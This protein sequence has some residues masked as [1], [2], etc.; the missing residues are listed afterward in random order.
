MGHRTR[1]GRSP[2]II[3]IPL[4]TL[5]A[6]TSQPLTVTHAP[7]SLRIVAADSCEPLVEELAAAYEATHPWVTVRVETLNSTLAEETLRAG[8]ADL[9]ALSWLEEDPQE[10]LWSV[11]FAT[12]AVALIIN[13]ANPV[14][15]LSLMQVQFIFRGQLSDWSSVTDN[16][17]AEIQVVSREEEAG[18]RA[19]F[20][21][22]VM[23]HYDVTLTAVV[24]PSSQAVIEY[25][26]TVPTAVGYVSTLWLDDRV[27]VLPV[28]GL[29]P[30]EETVADGSYPLSRPLYL[31]APAEP[32]GELQEFVQWVLGPQGQA[33]VGQRYGQVK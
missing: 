26:A 22:A 24:M 16:W 30:T 3:L 33:L 13:P 25:V 12:D 8:G 32:S 14:E 9:A 10:P 5:A 18:T 17:T 15:A 4:W 31:A 28:E 19:A 1:I 20:E 6:C 29:L 2:L 11:P 27:R 7:L 21:A 23:G